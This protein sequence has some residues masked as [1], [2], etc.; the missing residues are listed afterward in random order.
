MMKYWI[1]KHKEQFNVEPNVIGMFWNDQ[2]QLMNGIIE[3]IDSNK[4][5][6]EYLMLSKEEQEAFDKGDLI[7]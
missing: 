2:E 4:P 6:D 1:N 5:Y 7:F 3:A